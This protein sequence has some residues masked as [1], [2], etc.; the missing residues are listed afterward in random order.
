MIRC[1]SV[2]SCSHRAAFGSMEFVDAPVH[3][4]QEMARMGTKNSRLHLFDATTGTGAV[5]P[6]HGTHVTRH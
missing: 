6:S 4:K 3:L 1:I 5:S 2:G